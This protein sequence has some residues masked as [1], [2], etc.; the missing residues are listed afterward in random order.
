MGKLRLR[1]GQR[2]T[3]LRLL[4]QVRGP[5]TLLPLTPRLLCPASGPACSVCH[6]T[7]MN[8]RGPTSVSPTSRT[9]T[10]ERAITT[11]SSLRRGSSHP[12]PSSMVSPS[13]TPPGPSHPV[14]GPWTDNKQ[15]GSGPSHLT[16]AIFQP[17]QAGWS[18]SQPIKSG[19]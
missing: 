17:V 3:L 19:P 9:S 5:L 11:A 7:T 12:G 8:P 6:T 18:I 2:S 16:V 1:E 14:H 13:P 15:S 10:A 4:E